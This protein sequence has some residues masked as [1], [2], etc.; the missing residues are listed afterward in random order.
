M[1]CLKNRQQKFEQTIKI[2][3]RSGATFGN[4]TNITGKT[5]FEKIL[6]SCWISGPKFDLYERDTLCDILLLPTEEANL[7]IDRQTDTSPRS[8]RLPDFLPFSY[9][10]YK[11]IIQKG[12]GH[13]SKCSVHPSYSI[14]QI[15]FQIRISKL[16][17]K[18][19]EIATKARR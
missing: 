12:F 13:V 9:I 3:L 4:M 18:K 15:I 11:S 5:T 10:L 8:H 17:L 19:F 2:I 6:T 7:K 14:T 1:R 16:C